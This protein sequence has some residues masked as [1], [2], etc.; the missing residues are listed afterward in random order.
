V[1]LNPSEKASA[2]VLK[3]FQCPKAEYLTII[4]PPVPQQKRRINVLWAWMITR[5]RLRRDL[6]V[7]VFL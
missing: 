6:T 3:V 7:F 5:N 1:E 2:L 4:K